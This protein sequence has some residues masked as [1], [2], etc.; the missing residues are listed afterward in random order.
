MTFGIEVIP[1]KYDGVGNFSE[2]LS[3]VKKDGYWR[4]IN[5]KDEEVISLKYDYVC[6]FSEGLAKVLKDGKW[7]YINKKGEKVNKKGEKNK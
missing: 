1:L 3:A 2:E 7:F 5:K 4:F 6:N